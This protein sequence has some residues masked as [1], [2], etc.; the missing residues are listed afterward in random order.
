MAPDVA[1]DAAAVR[2]GAPGRRAGA[3][4]GRR[5]RT[6]RR[7]G[8]QPEAD[9]R[10]AGPLPDRPRRP[11]SRR[12]RVR[13]AR[14]G[15]RRGPAPPGARPAGPAHRGRAAQRRWSARCSSRWRRCTGRA[16]PRPT[17]CCCSGPTTSPRRAHAG[18]K[19]KSGDPYI[20]HPLAVATILAG[21]G[22]D[23]TTLVAALLHDTV[24]DTGV[25]L[26]VDHR[27]TSA[28]RWRTSSTASPRSTR[29]S[30]GDAAAGRDDPQDDRRDGP[31]PAGAGHQA[32]RPAAQHAHAALPPAGE[33][34]EE[35]ARDAGDPR[36]AGPPAGHEHD[37]VGAGGPR[38][39][40]PLPEAVRRDRP[41]GR[42]A[43][44]V[45]GHLPGRGH[46]RGQRPAQGG[47][48]RGG[49]H[50]PAQALLLDLPEDDRP[51]PRLHRHLG[52]GRH[53]DPGR[54]GARLL[55]G[56]GHH[57]RP[58]AAGARAASRTSWRCRSSTCTSRCT[59]R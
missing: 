23:T 33:A 49:R 1:A 16:T 15:R 56:A 53:P 47:E 30:S 19:R 57:A 43:G 5:R 25:T 34:G 36:P 32:R 18:Q 48:D 27:T 58:L 37:Q 39:R 8:E 6:S 4:R 51:R 42:R 45:P 40:H 54:L 14:R 22:M 28:S 7:A 35:G 24:E 31:R 12:R 50:R 20:T 13:A 59:P 44:A 46:Q 52:P 21:L 3:G 26:R 2:P 9:V 17:W 29:S 41:A 11:P 38:L 10:S 55:R